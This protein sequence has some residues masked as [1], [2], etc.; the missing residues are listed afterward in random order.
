MILTFSNIHSATCHRNM[1]N[2]RHPFRIHDH[3]Y[4]NWSKLIIWICYSYEYLAVVTFIVKEV[5]TS[6][7]WWNYRNMLVIHGTETIWKVA[8]HVKAFGNIFPVSFACWK[9]Q[10]ICILV[11]SYT[12]WFKYER[13]WFVCKEAALRSSCATLREWNHNLHPPSCSG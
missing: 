3:W 13:D 5:W 9:L 10:N 4:Q 11:Y 8:F 2:L 6:S 12:R 1:Y 7:G